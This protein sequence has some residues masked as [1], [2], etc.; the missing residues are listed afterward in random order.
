MKLRKRRRNI[1]CKSTYDIYVQRLWQDPD[2]KEKRD[3]LV[4]KY[5]NMIKFKLL[6]KFRTT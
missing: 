3:K 6:Y 1:Y 2:E 4:G 5:G